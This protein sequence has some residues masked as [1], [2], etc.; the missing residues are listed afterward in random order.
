MHVRVAWPIGH[1]TARF[2]QFLVRIHPRQALFGCEFHDA[3]AVVQE[4]TIRQYE[5]CTW[6]FSANGRKRIVE[7]RR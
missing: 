1:Q 3:R 6:P 4:E 7:L 5:Q 2:Y